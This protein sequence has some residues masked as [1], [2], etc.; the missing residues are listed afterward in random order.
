M[1]CVQIT[2]ENNTFFAIAATVSLQF[3]YKTKRANQ[4][5]CCMR[6]NHAPGQLALQNALDLPLNLVERDLA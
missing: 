6:H 2:Q 3:A 1:R 5:L 4:A